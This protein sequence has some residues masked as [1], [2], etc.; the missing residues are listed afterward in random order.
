[1]AISSKQRQK[2]LERKA[3]KKKSLKINRSISLS[4]R[5]AAR[6]STCPIH[7]CLVPH[8]LFEIGIGNVMVSRK[9]PNGNIAVSVFL[10][11]IFCLGVKDAFFRV[12]K[13][14]EY[15]NKLIASLMESHEGQT[16]KSVDPSC[17]RKLLEGAVAYAEELGFSHHPDHKN[18]KNIFGDI[19]SSNCPIKYTYGKDGKPFYVRG[20]SET[21]EKARQIVNHLN[22][23][24]GEGGFDYMVMLNEEIQSSDLGELSLNNKLEKDSLLVRRLSN[25][26]REVSISAVLREMQRPKDL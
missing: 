21:V 11:D 26:R 23:R 5:K 20:P 8:G 3:K 2:R 16:F 24:C 4:K 13:E 15:E 1:M 17:A 10:V 19:D 6:Y 18:A 9:P 25:R 7:E 22:Q 14:G 12:L